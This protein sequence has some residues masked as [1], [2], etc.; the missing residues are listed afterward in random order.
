MTTDIYGRIPLHYAC[1]RGHVDVVK[2]LVKY[3]SADDSA[4]AMQ[5]IESTSTTAAPV[6]ESVDYK[7]LDNFTPLIH[8]IVHARFAAVKA[9]LELGARVDPTSEADHIPINLACQY[10]SVSI[11]D[12]LLQYH[13][14]ILP[15]AEGL[16]PQH[17]VPRSGRS[18][19]ILE[20]LKNYGA[21]L[22]QPDKLYQWTPLSTLR[23]KVTCLAC[24]LCLNWVWT[25]MHWTKRTSPPCTTL[26][27]KA[28]S[29]VYVC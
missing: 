21:N 16:Y 8:G 11:V 28:I 24:S 15:D 23:A 25:L 2:E 14:Q 27:G 20:M 19:Q 17:L 10:G 7:D 18:P 3:D 4:D 26:H 6:G 5:G 22:D 12:L 13:P 1:M 9:V 29:I